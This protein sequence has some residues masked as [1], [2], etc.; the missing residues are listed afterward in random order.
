MQN[1]KIA[2]LLA[3]LGSPE[4]LSITS[5][6][7]YLKNFL[8]DSRV[9]DLPYYL[10]AFVVFFF[11]LPFRPKQTLK[12]YKAIWDFEKNQSPLLSITQEMVLRLQNKIPNYPIDFGMRYGKPSLKEKLEI[13]YNQGIRY[14]H[15]IPLY[16]QYS[17]STYGSLIAEIS[18][19]N[20]K[21]WDPLIITY[22]PPF[23][24]QKE[25][26]QLWVDKIQKNL[27]ND[28][29]Y[30]LV[31]S[32]HG[33]PIRHIRKSDPFHNCL[34]DNCCNEL[35]EYCYKSQA[36]FLSKSIAEKLKHKNW[37][38]AYQSR[39]GKEEWT[40]PYLED[41][42]QRIAQFH[43]KILI[44]PLSFVTDCLET[45]EE[46]AITL[47]NQYQKKLQNLEI[48]VLSSLNVDEEWIHFLEKKIL[49]KISLVSEA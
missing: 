11:I 46:L 31:F 24:D 2:F 27:A 26:I 49:K 48:R 6:R 13:F 15:I 47:T 10:R 35:K 12:K 39:L 19:I 25:F 29:D 41:E 22:E 21:F 44:V 14:V 40:K 34:K 32:F 16:P 45:K 30:F 36:F 37:T 38:I 23:G 5:V 8:L 42:I 33:I 3:N 20:Q 4:E 9:I 1:S 18:K 17:T 43:K 7:K 28:S